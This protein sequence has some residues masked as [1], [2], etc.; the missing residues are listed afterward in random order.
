[1]EGLFTLVP[2]IIFVAFVVVIGTIIVSAGK[3]M[4]EWSDNNAQPV[5]TVPARVVAKRPETRGTS[6]PNGGSV[7]TTY[8]VTF[9]LEAGER[10]EYALGGKEYGLLAEG[11]AG[12]LTYQG[13]RYH[14]FDR[15]G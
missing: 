1:M 12:T 7:S 8:Y 6:G 13:T 5:R 10:V 4:A 15:R 14:G 11:D 3:G 9:E 2:V